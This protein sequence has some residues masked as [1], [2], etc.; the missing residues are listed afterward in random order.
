MGTT[1]ARVA[2]AIAVAALSVGCTGNGSSTGVTPSPPASSVTSSPEPAERSGPPEA[3]S[4]KPGATKDAK[5]SIS[6]DVKP[7][8][9][10]APS[11]NDPAPLPKVK[12]S[13]K[14]AK[15][16]V[17]A[18][19]AEMKGEVLYDDGV[20]LR[21]AKVEFGKETKEGPGRFPGRAH[22]ILSLEIINGGKKAI[23]LDTTVVTVLDDED[24]QVAPVYLEDAD[25][26]DFAG[27]VKPGK[28]AKARYAFALAEDARSQVTVVVD[29]DGVH[30]SAVFRGGLE[31]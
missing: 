1:K 21:I 27:S 19:P 26:S 28:T 30:T 31:P 17:S 10:S 6:P 22:V 29:F 11:D 20:T 14:A 24:Q 25:V 9:T 15:P 23:N 13:D 18:D 8:K 7:T 16:T 2:A 3:S 5:P 4:S 12:R